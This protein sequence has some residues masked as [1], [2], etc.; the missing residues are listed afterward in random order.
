M[1]RT[2]EERAR[3]TKIFRKTGIETPELDS[4]CLIDYVTGTT[5]PAW[6]KTLCLADQNH[7]ANC[8][9]RRIAGEPVSR[10]VGTK[11]FWSLNL[12]LGPETLVPRPDSETLVRS[13]VRQ[14]SHSHPRRILDLGVGSG[15]L[16]LAL[17][18]EFPQAWGIGIDLSFG[19]AMQAQNNSRALGLARRSA[20]C[21]SDWNSAFVTH[22]TQSQRFDLIVSNPPYIVTSECHVLP[23]EVQADPRLAL[24]GGSDGLAAYRIL[25]E[26]I[27]SLLTTKGFVILEAGAGQAQDIWKIFEAKGLSW[28]RSDLDLGG[29]PRSLI[30]SH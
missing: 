26:R 8:A 29:H 14:F 25:A 5:Y 11:E 20:F 30:F 13:A 10:I 6:P 12:N 28:V 18:T 9:K 2:T 16:L 1:I 4:R 15:C 22:F 3:L 7:L 23:L 19:A 17:L 24:D 21:V 27:P